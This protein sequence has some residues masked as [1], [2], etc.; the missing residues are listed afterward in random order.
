MVTYPEDWR[1]VKLGEA[2][3]YTQPTNYIENN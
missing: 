2:L 1:E 3:V